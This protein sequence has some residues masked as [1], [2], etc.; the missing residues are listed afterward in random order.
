V[1][2][3]KSVNRERGHKFQPTGTVSRNPVCRGSLPMLQNSD[4]ACLQPPDVYMEAASTAFARRAATTPAAAQPQHGE[5]RGRRAG[6][7]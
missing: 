4:E 6:R 1:S 5:G 3:T 2:Y 7:R